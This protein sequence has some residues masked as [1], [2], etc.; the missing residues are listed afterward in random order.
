MATIDEAATIE[1]IDRKN[2]CA[3]FNYG[4]IAIQEDTTSGDVTITL[5]I[6]KNAYNIFRYNVV[7]KNILNISNS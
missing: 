5:N 4:D 7:A 3:K 1:F 2:K 6:I